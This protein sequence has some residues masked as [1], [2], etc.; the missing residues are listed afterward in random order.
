MKKQIMRIAGLVAL[1]YGA[2]LEARDIRSPLPLYTGYRGAFYYPIEREDEICN[3]FGLEVRAWGAGYFREAIDA[4]GPAASDNCNTNGACVSS[5]AL[6]V[7]ISVLIFGTPSFTIGQSFAGGSA[8]NSF[9]QNP[10]VNI[11]HITPAY[12]YNEKGAFFGLILGKRFGCDDQW[13]AGVR[14]MLPYRDIDVDDTCSDLVGEVL[15]DVFRQR[16]EVFASAEQGNVDV[17]AWAARLDFLSALNMIG[18]DVNDNTVPL[19]NY[20]DMASGIPSGALTIGGQTIGYASPPTFTNPSVAAIDSSDGS[21]PESVRWANGTTLPVNFINGDGSGLANLQRGKF[22]N[23]PAT[24]VPLG[25]LPGQQGQLWIVPNVDPNTGELTAGASSVFTQIESSSNNIQPAITDFFKQQGISFCVGRSKGI[26]D[27]DAEFYITHNRCYGFAELQL[28]IRAPT[29]KRLTDPLLL[30]LQPLGN[31][32]HCEI[33]PGLVL[34]CDYF[35]SV[36]FKVDLTYSWVLKRTEIL[37][38]PFKGATVRN[39]GPAIPGKV[40]WGYFVGDFDVT[41]V[42]PYNQCMGWT[43]GYEAYVKQ[44]DKI[45]LC[46]DKAVDFAG[47]LQDLDASILTKDSKRVAHRLRTEIF[48]TGVCS[49]IFAGFSQVIAGKNVTRD[50]DL[51]LGLV[52]TF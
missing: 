24:Y 11:S 33:R 27:L 37:P 6:K 12:D 42:H 15:S 45:C 13:T 14:L 30:A 48:H 10:F 38:A 3:C 25:S 18:F 22:T 19:V 28:G 35:D 49:N 44:K 31:N 41:F 50:M 52:A 1:V 47:Q 40:H 20:N 39:I 8:G 36:K 29:G 2:A 17:N 23:A 21:V 7:P 43:I 4:Y 26:G 16:Q 34:G 5:T 46:S 32:G 51:Y 9:P